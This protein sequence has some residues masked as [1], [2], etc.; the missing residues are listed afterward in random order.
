[1]CDLYDLYDLTHVP[2]WEPHN[3]HD[4]LY[5]GHVV[6]GLDIHS[7]TGPAHPAH[8]LITADKFTA[9]SCLIPG[10]VHRFRPR[11]GGGR[12]PLGV[13]WG[14]LGGPLGVPWGS[15]GRKVKVKK[16]SIPTEMSRPFFV[17]DGCCCCC[18]CC[19]KFGFCLPLHPESTRLPTA[20]DKFGCL[21]QFWYTFEQLVRVFYVCFCR[22]SC[23]FLGG[24]NAAHA[25][26]LLQKLGQQDFCSCRQLV[27]VIS[28]GEFGESRVWQRI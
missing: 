19:C 9:D 13:P 17:I 18:C 24:G 1:M 15:Q 20:A 6:P 3:L 8:H 4:I 26:R 16:E 25:K 23:F 14:S 22:F 21:L 11:R 12:D 10:I 2:G 7:H 28:L 5:V 27:C